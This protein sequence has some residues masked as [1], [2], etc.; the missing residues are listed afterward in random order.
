MADQPS[1]EMEHFAQRFA[2]IVMEA[3]RQESARQ[4]KEIGDHVDA[5]IG[6]LEIRIEMRLEALHR[7]IAG[8]IQ[9][10]QVVLEK[11]GDGLA[12]N[13]DAHARIEERLKQGDETLKDLK[14]RL[15]RVETVTVD[16]RITLASLIG[17]ATKI[18]IPSTI[19][20]AT[21][22]AIMKM[23]GG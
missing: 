5:T 19:G 3:A 17:G 22:A 13:A 21:A 1:A 7:E 20:G 2:A 16:N 6:A 8:R 18:A 15:K 14:E 23:L 12:K 11:H 10:V 4:S 9:E